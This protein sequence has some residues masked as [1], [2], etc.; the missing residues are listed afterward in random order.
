MRRLVL[1]WFVTRRFLVNRKGAIA[2]SVAL[3]ALLS[4][5]GT[6]AALAQGRIAF[7]ST[8]GGT[9]NA[10]IFV[11][12]ADGTAQTRVTSDPASDVEPTWS[13]DGSRLAFTAISFD[14][15][16]V[17][18]GHIDVVNVD[19]S[20]QTQLTN[21]PNPDSYPAWSPDG[22]EVAY[23]RG[24]VDPLGNSDVFVMSADGTN[25]R[26]LTNNPAFDGFPSWSPDGSKIAFTSDRDGNAEIYT[27]N[28]DG[29]DQ[30]RLTDNPASDAHPAWSPDGTRIAFISDRDGSFQ[31]YS[32]S[33][34]G[35]DERRLTSGQDQPGIPLGDY[36]PTW[37]P[38]GTTIAY[39]ADQNNGIG[40]ALIGAGGGPT[41][42]LPALGF[43]PSWEPAP[44]DGVLFSDDFESGD[45]SKWSG[46]SGVSVQTEIVSSGTYAARATATGTP[47]FA[48]KTFATSQSELYYRLRFNVQSRAAKSVYLLRLRSA[49]NAI[50]GL[51]LGPTGLL[52]YRNLFAAGNTCGAVRPSQAAWHTA[53]V[54]VIVNGST[55][56][57]EV[58]LDG[59]ELVGATDDLGAAGV[60]GI[61]L[62]DRASGK[63][64]DVAFDDVVVGTN[65]LSPTAP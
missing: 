39:T 13:P 4:M 58:W 24:P 50:M 3:S 9:E 45:L 49:N 17:Q 65:P 60:S 2:L 43:G 8:R 63:T 61:E 64:F 51:Y 25:Q 7:S 20:G 12:N 53:L 32:M 34:T 44:V 35:G 23:T 42:P 47:A 56:T 40:I 26:D 11:M 1:R 27:M 48:Y 28:A 6:S 30:T 41:T 29:S 57:V 10:D 19:G 59:T 52:C 31:L 55:S 54:H 14:S 22:K 62:G 36:A 46:A 5:T 33:A 21:A 16:Q 15:Q 18:P 37:S 38:D